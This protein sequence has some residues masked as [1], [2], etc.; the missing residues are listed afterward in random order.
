MST[1][2]NH[3]I[4]TKVRG[5]AAEHGYSQERIAAKLGLSR[6]AVG[7]RVRGEVPIAASEVLVLALEFDVPVARFFPEPGTATTRSPQLSEAAA[8]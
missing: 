2:L 6:G 7:Q 3:R 8:S 5:L 1:E 4:A